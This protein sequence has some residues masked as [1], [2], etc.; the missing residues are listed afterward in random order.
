MSFYRVCPR[1]GA[2]LDPGERCDCRDQEEDRPGGANAGT[3]K[4]QQGG[5]YQRAHAVFHSTT[6]EGGKAR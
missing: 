2:F 1:C 5:L 3:V 4:G 6:N